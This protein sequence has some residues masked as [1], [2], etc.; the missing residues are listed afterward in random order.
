MAEASINFGP[1]PGV[2]GYPKRAWDFVRRWPVIPAVILGL[3]VFSAVFA[4]LV[5]PHS[6]YD[7]SLRDRTTAPAWAEGGS[8]EYI[9]GTDH[10]GRDV[11]S[12]VIHG[13]RISL[14][15]TVVALGSGI[16]IGVTLGLIAGWYGG[17]AD[18]ILARIVDIWL[19]L[20]FLL[21][22]LVVVIVFGQSVPTMMLVLAMVSW[23]TFVRNVRAEVLTL[24][25]RDY[26]ELARVSGASTPRILIRHI[27]PGVVNTVF[28]IATLN[29]GGL[30]LTEATLSF[31]GAGIP[32]PTPAWGLMVAE[33]RDYLRSHW[34]IPVV[35]GT[36]IALVVMSLNFLGDWLRD[37]FDPRLRQI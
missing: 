28:V 13:A 30:I 25:T 29:V 22:A 12:R 27:I 15:V 23:S 35:P 16:L 7:Q 8:N 37:R 6:P 18:E 20:P 26:V 19:A 11:L 10:V 36:A 1:R 21:V 24:K 9:L 17:F 33:G 32:S 2:L 14:M 3:L 4:P 31:L 5:A 34:G